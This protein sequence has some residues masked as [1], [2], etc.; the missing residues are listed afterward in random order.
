MRQ[1]SWSARMGGEDPV[2]PGV[3]ERAGR[4]VLTDQ[5]DEV[6]EPLIPRTK[7]H[8]PEELAP[9]RSGT[10]RTES[11][12]DRGHHWG[13][14]RRVVDPGEVDGHAVALVARTE[15]QPVGGD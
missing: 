6:V 4:V 5:R 12:L 9:V 15:P 7:V 8:V 3:S 11:L 10:E 1:T 2:E 13:D 14:R